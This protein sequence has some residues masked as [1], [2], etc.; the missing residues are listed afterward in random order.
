MGSSTPSLV[1]SSDESLEDLVCSQSET[2]AQL[3]A[4]VSDL[5]GQLIGFKLA[6]EQ[7]A[8]IKKA[9]FS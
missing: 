5:K 1:G 6:N 4:Q 7:L 9:M 8:E 3:R 2:I